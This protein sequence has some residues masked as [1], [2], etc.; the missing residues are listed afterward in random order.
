LAAYIEMGARGLVCVAPTHPWI[1]HKHG[2]E[3]TNAWAPG[4]Y[5]RS[6]DCAEMLVEVNAV[7]IASRE[8]VLA[9]RRYGFPLLLYR[10][11]RI[12]AVLDIDTQD[13]LDEARLAWPSA[14]DILSDWVG[15]VE[16]CQKEPNT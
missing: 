15:S 16:M 5:P 9:G 8:D 3:I 14:R 13:D 11:P 10:L 7:Q 6:Q 4:P 2:K 12:A 1:W